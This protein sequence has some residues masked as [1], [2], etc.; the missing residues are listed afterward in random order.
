MNQKDRTLFKIIN[1]VDKNIDKEDYI[2]CMKPQLSL[3]M[4]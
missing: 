1:G 2:T 4:Y 3:N